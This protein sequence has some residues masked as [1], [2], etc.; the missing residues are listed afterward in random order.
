MS[1][2]LLKRVLDVVRERIMRG[3][4]NHEVV[5]VLLVDPAAVFLVKLT[6]SDHHLVV[7]NRKLCSMTRNNR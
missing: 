3:P 2:L 1:H 6:T 5:E 4:H 7:Q